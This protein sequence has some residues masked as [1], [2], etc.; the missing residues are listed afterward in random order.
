MK[1]YLNI[2]LSR[3]EKVATILIA[4]WLIAGCLVKIPPVTSL[5]Y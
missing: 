4:I 2:Q 3:A 1:K 5:G